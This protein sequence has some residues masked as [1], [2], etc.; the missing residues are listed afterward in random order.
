MHRELR[1]LKAKPRL[2]P[3]LHPPLFTVLS[4]QSIY[5]LISP[6]IPFK[7][8]VCHGRKGQGLILLLVKMMTIN[9]E[10]SVALLFYFVVTDRNCFI[11]FKLWLSYKYFCPF[12]LCFFFSVWF[13][14]LIGI[15]IRLY[16]NFF[17]DPV[18]LLLNFIFETLKII[19]IWT[20]GPLKVKN[21]PC[22][23]SDTLYLKVILISAMFILNSP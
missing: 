18:L 12:I 17:S 1:V 14:S 13:W 3:E 16:G 22:F 9:K 2:S 6:L 11:L 8:G 23:S 10:H 5:P 21:H 15:W 20:I 19:W 7:G 4:S